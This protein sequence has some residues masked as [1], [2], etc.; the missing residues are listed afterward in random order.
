M[1][2]GGD[3][4]KG[5]GW[6]AYS[7]NVSFRTAA[8]ND[9][10]NVPGSYSAL[11]VTNVGTPFFGGFYMIPEIRI[12][13]D[14]RG[15][16]V[17]FHRSEQDC[18]GN[19]DLD[20]PDSSSERLA[21]V[22]YLTKIIPDKEW[23][24]K[25][26]TSHLSAMMPTLGA[27]KPTLNGDCAVISSDGEGDDGDDDDIERTVRM[28]IDKVIS[29][30]EDQFPGEARVVGEAQE[31]EKTHLTGGAQGEIPLD[32]A[33]TQMRPI[34]ERDLDPNR[35]L[36]NNS[37]D[38]F[39]VDS[40]SD[41]G[42]FHSALETTSSERGR[43]D[44]QLV[45]GG[46]FEY[47][48]V[49]GTG[50]E[51]FDGRYGGDDATSSGDMMAARPG[52]GAPRKQ[53]PARGK[54]SKRIAAKRKAGESEDEEDD[55]SDQGGSDTD[56]HVEEV[57]AMRPFSPQKNA[58]GRRRRGKYPNSKVE[59]LIKWKGYDE[60]QNSWEPEECCTGA[61]RKIEE[62]H[63]RE[64]VKQEE[65]KKQ[66]KSGPTVRYGKRLG[67]N[68]QPRKRQASTQKRRPGRPRKKPRK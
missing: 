51:G 11:Y 31:R 57:M 29:D 40:D 62:F 32:M 2:P 1:D 52:Q 46:Y 13:F 39:L 12:G 28:L 27:P 47:P 45:E 33:D 66:Q 65:E 9:R 34:M 50:E 60:S 5:T 48:E 63:A 21:F 20:R 35:D 17:L 6:N 59:Y 58:E 19:S 8:H 24:E 30:T 53:A 7:V 18:H 3:L 22:F 67:Q 38:A 25:G 14:C 43:G 68:Q 64:K 42:Q 10:K 15:G 16:S 23:R 26:A 54:Q 44:G 4:F 41:S 49:L 37:A 61:P 36:Y 56:Y 55:S